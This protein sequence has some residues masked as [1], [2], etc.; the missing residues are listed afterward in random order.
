MPAFPF[1]WLALAAALLLHLPLARAAFTDADADR[2]YDAFNQTFYQSQSGGRAYYS[3][4]TDGGRAWFWGQANMIEM[5]ADSNDRAPTQ[6]K[7]DQLAALC[8]GFT[9]YHGTNWA[10]NEYNDDIIWACIVFTKAYLATNDPQF[11]SR[12]TANFDVVWNRAWATNAGGGLYWKGTSGG[13]NA[14]VNAPAAIAATLLYDITGNTTYLD[15]ARSIITWMDANL[16]VST[17]AID[18]HIT[19]EGTR[20]GW[21]FTYNQG[22]YVGAC[23]AL[24]RLTGEISYLE[25]AIMAARYTRDSMCNTAG[26]FPNHGTSG[27]GGGFNGIGIRWIARMVKDQGL[28]DEFFPWLKANADAAWNNRRPVEDLSWANWRATTPAA[29]EVLYSFGC[30]GSVVALQVVPSVDPSFAAELAG[31]FPS[32]TYEAES[33]VFAGGALVSVEH[34][35]FRGTGYADYGTG[36]A[37]TITWTVNAA[38]AGSHWI[39]FRYANGGTTNRPLRLR[40]N[41]AVVQDI[42]FQATGGWKT[43]IHSGGISVPLAAGPNTIQLVTTMTNRPNIDLLYVAARPAPAPP[44]AIMLFDGTAPSLATNWKRDED[45][46]PPNWSVSAGAMAVTQAPARNDISTVAGF[47]D[48]QLHLEWLAPP[49]GL[50]QEAANSGVKLQGRYEIQI[51]NTPRGQTPWP[52]SAAAIYR[53]KAPSTNASLGAGHW[54]SYDIDFTAARWNGSVKLSD[55]RVTVSWNGVLVHDNVTISSS[56]AASPA[57]S[58][59]WHPI[60][61]QAATSTA[62]GPVSFRNIWVLPKTSE[63]LEAELATRVG[64]TVGTGNPGYSGTGFADYGTAIGESITWTVEAEKAAHHSISFRYANGV[65]SDRPLNLFVNGSLIQPLPFGS[66]GGW[67]DW[68]LTNGINVPLQPGSNTIQLTSTLNNGPNVDYLHVGL[69]TAPTTPVEFW[70]EW[71]DQANLTGGERDPSQDTDGDGQT[72]LW[73]YATGGNPQI[74]DLTNALGDHRVPRMALVDDGGTRFAE[75]TFIRRTDH[76]ARGLV[77]SAESTTT[78]GPTPWTAHAV[79]LAGSP[80]P[81]GDGTHERVT[82]RIN[83]PL[84]AEPRMFFRMRVNLAG[85]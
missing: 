3:E 47:R 28:W 5:V 85:G 63:I 77:F 25:N 68:I 10:W 8:R 58:A 71:L 70:N 33:A 2:I 29:P 43:W 79:T 59:G 6:N 76:Q 30:Y 75:F 1:R 9:D 60:L 53:E 45:A 26:I 54:Q 69:L 56:T 57:E 41:G 7:R 46:G 61:L 23:S 42:P 44:G 15:K 55:A 51:L 38:T 52:D 27:D 18:D 17:G 40:I 83:L 64:P 21:R 16:V 20:V 4:N 80:V 31:P 81:V 48:F 13:R 37:E 24:Y 39:S 82:L 14:C 84:D 62:S 50:G 34:S 19:T 11:L 49:G 35:G 67:T 74:P 73:E 72:H 22:T 36:T 32:A 66:S 78:L 65:T 12:A